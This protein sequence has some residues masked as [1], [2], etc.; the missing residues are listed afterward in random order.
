MKWRWLPIGDGFV[1]AFSSRDTDS[2]LL[3]REVDSVNVWTKS[4]DKLGHIMRGNNKDISVKIT[5]YVW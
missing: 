1:E 5:P 3:Q 2:Y 4:S